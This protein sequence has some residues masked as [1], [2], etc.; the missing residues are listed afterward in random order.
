[1]AINHNEN[2][3]YKLVS[4]DNAE[5]DN[6]IEKD[7]DR[8]NITTKD[9]KITDDLKSKKAKLFNILKAYAVYDSEVGYCQGTNFII[10][11]LLSN[12]NSERACFWVFV[13]IMND[14]NWRDLFI[15]NTPKLR[16]MLEVLGN[17]IESKLPDIYEH[18]S[19]FKDVSIINHLNILTNFSINMMKY[20]M[21]Y[22]LIT[23]YLCFLIIF[24]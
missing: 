20:L 24:L 3:Y 22:L 18:L 8:T 9:E 6:V 14:K 10:A 13:Q 2:I 4:A 17:T 7:I 1:V 11:V 16:R 21:L 19:S 15:K 23:F 5:I 12:I